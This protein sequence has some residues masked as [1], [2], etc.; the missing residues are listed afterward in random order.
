MQAW[1]IILCA[2]G[3]EKSVRVR[4]CDMVAWLSVLNTAG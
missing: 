1:P 4:V 3:R 2:G